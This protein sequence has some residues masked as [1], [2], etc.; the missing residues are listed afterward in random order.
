MS[1]NKSNKGEQIPSSYKVMEWVLTVLVVGIFIAFFL[2][3][4]VF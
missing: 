1:G 4:V 2:M 3:I